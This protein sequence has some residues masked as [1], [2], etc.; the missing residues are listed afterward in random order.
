LP[1]SDFENSRDIALRKG[2]IAAR[3]QFLSYASLV[4]SFAVAPEAGDGSI[5]ALVMIGVS[6]PV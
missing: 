5:Q 3:N 4:D 1:V 2:V 6:G